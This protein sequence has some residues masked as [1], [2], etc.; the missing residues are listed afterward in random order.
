MNPESVTTGQLFSS[1]TAKHWF[2]LFSAIGSIAGGGYWA[3]KTLVESQSAVL[4]AELKGSLAQAQAKLEVSQSRI[5]QLSTLLPQWQ[6]AYQKLQTDFAQQQQTVASLTA[7]LGR[8]NNCAF[9]HEQIVAT[10]RLI[11]HPGGIIAYSPQK[12]DNE[13]EKERLASLQRRLEGYTQQLNSCNK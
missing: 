7:Q 2:A 6:S 13:K 5:E 10:Q 12:E 3:G 11:E 1:F 4:Q 9:I 8:S